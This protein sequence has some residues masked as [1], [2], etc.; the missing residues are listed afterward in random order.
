MRLSSRSLSFIGAGAL[1]TSHEDLGAALAEARGKGEKEAAGREERSSQGV[2]TTMGGQIK[3]AGGGK[4]EEGGER[5]RM[6]KQQSTKKRE[7]AFSMRAPEPKYEVR[8]DD[9]E[10]IAGRIQQDDVER[11]QLLS[12][13]TTCQGAPRVPRPFPAF[14]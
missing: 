12:E 13:G 3:R 6:Q 1:S 4:G 2:L 9:K 7:W 5:K 14:A 11:G 10:D 8:G